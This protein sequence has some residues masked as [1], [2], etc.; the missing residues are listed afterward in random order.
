MSGVVAVA[1]QLLMRFGV[2]K[3]SAAMLHEPAFA[4]G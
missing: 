4:P 3:D 2:D 1:E